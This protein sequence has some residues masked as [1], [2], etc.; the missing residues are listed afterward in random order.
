MG[1]AGVRALA[2][3]GA[4]V[5]MADRKAAPDNLGAERVLAIDIG[6]DARIASVVAEA[7]ESSAV[8]MLFGTTPVFA[9][10]ARSK[11]WNWMPSISASR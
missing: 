6:D 5:V 10:S 3:S 1:E 7:G 2:A 9:M 11:A 4:R 8:S